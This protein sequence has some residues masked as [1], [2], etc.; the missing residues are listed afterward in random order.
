MK[1]FFN[2]K[3][4]TKT[5]LISSAISLMLIVCFAITGTVAWLI[6]AT[7]EVTDKFTFGDVEIELYDDDKVTLWGND[8]I[9]NKRSA[10]GDNKLIPGATIPFT[11][12]V[13][14]IGSEDCYVFIKVVPNA[15]L[16][17]ETKVPFSL[18]G[19]GW[20][21]VTGVENVYV[22]GTNNQPTRLDA[23]NN[24]F[25]TALAGQVTVNT[26]MTAAELATLAGKNPQPKITIVAYAIQA[27]YLGDADTAAEI[28]A[29]INP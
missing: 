26:S 13:K 3:F 11:P 2:K 18:S 8:A 19:T 28:W 23:G 22:Y 24:S 25:T 12:C 16:A 4:S 15:T 5:K 7:E 20:E 10:N 9:L 29:L 14:N 27:D 17:A 1:N 6:D 21:A